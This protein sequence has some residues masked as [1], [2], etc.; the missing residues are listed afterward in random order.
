MQ[1]LPMYRAVHLGKY[2]QYEK[3]FDNT[4]ES[5]QNMFRKSTGKRWQ[6]YIRAVCASA[7]GAI[8]KATTVLCEES[9]PIISLISP[10]IISLIS[11]IPRRGEVPAGEQCLGSPV[12]DF[13]TS[14][15]L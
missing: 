5:I 10:Q 12:S 8:K 15:Q 11:Q 14:D 2:E 3:P 7:Q 4:P 9:Q 1:T 6:F 13:A